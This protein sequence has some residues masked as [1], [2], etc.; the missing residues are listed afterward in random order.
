MSRSSIRVRIAY[1]VIILSYI[2]ILALI[3]N[4]LSSDSDFGGEIG[5]LALIFGI[6]SIGAGFLGGLIAPYSYSR[7]IK[8]IALTLG[9]VI[10]LFV[11]IFFIIGNEIINTESWVIIIFVILFIVILIGTVVIVLVTTAGLF[12]CALLG[13][14]IWKTLQYDY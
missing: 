9:V 7:L 13:S 3:L 4:T 12:V 1:I 2:T 5:R 11:I 8:Y 14:L 10:I 6:A